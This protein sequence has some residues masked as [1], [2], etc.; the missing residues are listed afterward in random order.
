MTFTDEEKKRFQDPAKAKEFRLALEQELNVSATVGAIAPMAHHSTVD[1]YADHEGH[2]VPTIRAGRI[3][4]LPQGQPGQQAR[5][6]GEESVLCP[7]NS[8]FCLVLMLHQFFLSLA[9]A[10]DV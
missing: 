1:A 7:S 9:S 2:T 8:C 3:D 4:C 10:P 6:R 5:S